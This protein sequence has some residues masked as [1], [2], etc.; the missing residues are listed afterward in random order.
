M[1]DILYTH[2][3]QETRVHGDLKQLKRW[4]H[5]RGSFTE[6]K[7]TKIPCKQNLKNCSAHSSS[8]WGEYDHDRV[9]LV[10]SNDDNVI[11]V[12]CDGVG[13]PQYQSLYDTIISYFE[14][15]TYVEGSISNILDGKDKWHIV[16]RAN[17]KRGIKCPKLGIEIFASRQF[18][19][20]TGEKVSDFGLTDQTFAVNRLITLMNSI[21]EGEQAEISKQ[22]YG[23]APR[24]TGD[25]HRDSLLIIGW[26]RENNIPLC[27][28]SASFVRVGHCLKGCG[29]NDEEIKK[30]MDDDKARHYPSMNTDDA[31]K[32]IVSFRPKTRQ[33]ANLVAY[34]KQHGYKG[35]ALRHLQT[36]DTDEPEY[37][38][39]EMIYALNTELKEQM[40]SRLA[41]RGGSVGISGRSGGGKTAHA[42]D[43]MRECQ[44][45][46]WHNVAVVADMEDWEVEERQL[47]HQ[48]N[49]ADL[50]K[51]FI[52]KKRH[53]H[54][55]QLIE[56]IRDKVGDKTMGVICLDNL[57]MIGRRLWRSIRQDQDP[58]KFKITEDDCA[59]RFMTA[60]VDRIAEEFD[61]CV[62]VIAHP[63]KNVSGKDKFPGSE[64]WPALFGICYR[65]YRIN[66]TNVDEIPKAILERFRREKKSTKDWTLAAIFKPRYK[67]AKDYWL[68]MKDGVT[69]DECKEEEID[70]DKVLE[71]KGQQQKRQPQKLDEEKYMEDLEHKFFA[72]PDNQGKWIGSGEIKPF[73]K[74]LHPYVPYDRWVAMIR[75]HTTIAPLNKARE[76]KIYN[77]PYN[78][79]P[80]LWYPDDNRL[81]GEGDYQPRE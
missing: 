66:A 7:R 19:L 21:N 52:K 1:G 44:D 12:D 54:I 3:P 10:M 37:D 43:M 27:P 40:T 77:D 53:I 62:V 34:A 6:G 15:V 56:K 79:K 25:D 24:L 29:W 13:D 9:G 11:T 42:F 63:P 16:C 55:D 60:V 28:D 2:D 69:K 67:T 26:F 74:D 80:R 68:S 47:E 57:L 61:C 70:L 17:I 78:G 30:T 72:D 32:R 39:I 59:D 14:G 65:I 58:R 48:I 71:Q 45:K 46:S 18:I 64:I 76:P 4:I 8:N 50:G 51:I 23:K 22:V 41:A 38:E 33:I 35:P 5:V 49:E 31:M 81:L 36:P 75:R 73:M 20:M